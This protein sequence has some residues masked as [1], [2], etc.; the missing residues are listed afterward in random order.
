ML[1][2]QILGQVLGTG[3]GP[4]H[5]ISIH[6]FIQPLLTWFISY[7]LSG[8]VH[9]LALPIFSF[10]K[11]SINLDCRKSN[12]LWSQSDRVAKPWNYNFQVWQW[13]RKDFPGHKHIFW[14]SL[15][16][17]NGSKFDSLSPIAYGKSRRA[18][19]VNCFISILVSQRAKL[20]V[21][22]GEVSARGSL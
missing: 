15:P 5:R 21:Q 7:V 1:V 19:S 20:E 13:P 8:L 17:K 3:P 12:R 9:F 22:P 10:I 6:W 11:R 4:A 16:M 2:K 14:A 18:T